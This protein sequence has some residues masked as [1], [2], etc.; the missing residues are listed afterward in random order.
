M[1]TYYDNV[2]KDENT[3]LHFP[4]FKNGDGVQKL[5]ASMADD[6]ALSVC[7]L[8][9]FEDMKWNDNHQRPIKYWSRDIINSM[10]LLLQ[11][12]LYAKHLIYARQC[13]VTSDKPPKRLYTEMHTADGWWETQLRKDT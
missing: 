7:E 8:H 2:L 6:Q 12:P 5:V 4:S 9:T 1:K 11:Q 3:A 10:R 13:C